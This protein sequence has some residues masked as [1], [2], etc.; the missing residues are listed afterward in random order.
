M[1]KVIFC[2]RR[3]EG[4]SREAFQRYWLERHAP[5]VARLAGATGMVRY[6]QNHVLDSRLGDGF[7]KVRGTA[8][9]YD[10]VMEGWWESEEAAIAAFR[11]AGPAAGTQLL[12]D[13]REFIDLSRSSIFFA[14]EREI[15]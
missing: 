1:I 7:A 15:F 3:R 2:L 6:V 5:L 10:G 13:E 8:E 14:D 9:P 4:L 11:T 12:K